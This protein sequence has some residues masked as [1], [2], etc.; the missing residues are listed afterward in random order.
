MKGEV[1]VQGLR[2]KAYHGCLEEEASV[3]SDFV[4]DVVVTTDF[5]KAIAS[6]DLKDTADYVHL[7]SIVVNQMAIR[8]KLIEHVGKRIIDCIYEQ[9]Q[10]IESVEVKITKIN[11]PINTDVEAVCVVLRG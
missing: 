10:G 4:V 2:V 9:L 1:H 7:S 5:D 8:S 6:D 11:P 3:G